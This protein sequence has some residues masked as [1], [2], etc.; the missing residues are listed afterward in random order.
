[1]T[2]YVDDAATGM[3][4]GNTWNDAYP[5]FA[6]AVSAI[7]G[8][9]VWVASTHDEIVSGA[10]D[11]D[12]TNG[13][14]LKPVI[15]LSMTTG[16]AYSSRGAR[17]GGD[18]TSSG[19]ILAGHVHYY[20]MKM[21]T[22]AGD[23]QMND[24]T[25]DNQLY[26]DC[27]FTI[28]D[29]ANDRYFIHGNHS[30]TVC[31]N[32]TF[33]LFDQITFSNADGAR[34]HWI[35]CNFVQSAANQTEL[36]F[37]LERF[38]EATFDSCDLSDWDEILENT[39]NYGKLTVR[40]CLLKS[41]FSLYTGAAAAGMRLINEGSHSDTSMSV[42][43]LGLQELNDYY[44][45]ILSDLTRYRTGGA[46]DGLQANAHCWSM[47]TTAESSEFYEALE[48]PP[49]TR[50]VNP[51]ASPSGTTLGIV[52]NTRMVAKGTPVALTTDSGSS[53]T[54]TGVGTLQKIT[55]TL[56]SQDGA[57][58][59]IFIASGATM[60]NDDF[61]VEIQEPTSV[62]GPVTVKCFLAKPSTVVYV[63]PRIDI[64]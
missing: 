60:N 24:D 41:G 16:D 34:A 13:T 14:A 33:N 37:I 54:G 1:L 30:N 12:F 36:I 45:T 25:F 10:M 18:S 6:S 59:T 15:V 51:D 3:D 8:E 58:L 2:V 23:L 4:N 29:G 9:E 63:D 27:E 5:N 43:K 28:G 35:N 56:D 64:A 44:G 19:L 22:T 11:V 31:R 38:C 62:G 61:W 52:T 48:S 46:T 26:D 53:W 39:E 21:A 49:L 57:T 20:G 40:K 7:A 42:R 47:T 50:F 32:C 17:I 55:H